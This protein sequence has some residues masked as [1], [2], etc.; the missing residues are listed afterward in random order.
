MSRRKDMQD[1]LMVWLGNKI[2]YQGDY[3]TVE[4]QH[5][6][7]LYPKGERTS[8]D[9]FGRLFHDYLKGLPTFK[10]NSPRMI[11]YAE[12]EQGKWYIVYTKEMM[13][14]HDGV[15]EGFDLY[16]RAYGLYNTWYEGGRWERDVEGNWIGGFYARIYPDT[17][18]GFFI[19]SLFFPDDYSNNPLLF[20]PLEQWSFINWLNMNPLEVK[21]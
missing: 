19:N 6:H 11:P 17:P 13:R 5:S 9:E 15:E 2:G 21:G 14:Y 12:L 16:N 10:E 3:S 8:R 7:G 4:L 20:V 18:S 1:R